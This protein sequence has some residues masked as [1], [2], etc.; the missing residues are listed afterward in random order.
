MSRHRA[1]APPLSGG[2]GD[3]EDGGSDVFGGP[4]APS[5]GRAAW[6]AAV[7][8]RGVTG[9]ACF[10]ADTNELWV[11]EGHDD[12]ADFAFLRLALAHAQ[13]RVVY[14]SS[15][16][17]DA[18][19]AALSDA[20]AET[21]GAAADA[22]SHAAGAAAAAAAEDDA[23]GAPHAL[24]V[25]IEKAALFT[26]DAA[27]RRLVSTTVECVPAA[28]R[29]AATYVHALHALVRLDAE[30]QVRAAGALVAILQRDGML[31]GGGD[32][33]ASPARLASISEKALSG[34]LTIDAVSV[35]ALGIFALE[36]H[37]SRFCG[38]AKEGLSVFGIMDTCVTQVRTR[39][40]AH[41]RARTLTHARART[42]THDVRAKL[43]SS[44]LNPRLR[45]LSLPLRRLAS[46]CC[47]PG[48]GARWLI[49]RSW[50][51]A[52]TRWR[53]SWG[54]RRRLAR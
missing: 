9:F 18:F 37:P 22:D 33:D 16:S 7:H 2:G 51:R 23:A 46:A 30:A 47:A 49:W 12:S 15:K 13:P 6:A 40:H 21:A 29:D 42:F 19:L 54:A 28:Q 14:A 27:R 35:A 45:A 4:D 1:P 31:G 20:L 43:A 24:E 50:A 34:Y 5:G 38:T 53:F 52:T 48:S 10:E 32:A 36:A 17:D 26:L 25:R 41:A 39:T 8:V 3:E 11:A 44:A